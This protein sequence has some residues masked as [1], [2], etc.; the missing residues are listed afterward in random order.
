MKSII[1]VTFIFVFAFAMTVDASDYCQARQK[2]EA[3][4][5]LGKVLGLK[6]SDVRVVHFEPG[7]WTM[8][9]EN[10]VGFDRVTVAAWTTD[11][12]LDL[13]VTVRKVYD[14]FA[15][16]LGVSADCKITGIELRGE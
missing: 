12:A 16:Q 5:A 7:V 1:G 3:Q 8:G 13:D 15:T 9:M 10:S 4:I 2:L 14:V 6:T 11:P